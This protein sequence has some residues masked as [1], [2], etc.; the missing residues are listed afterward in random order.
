MLPDAP[1]VMKVP[2]LRNLYARVAASDDLAQKRSHQLR[3]F[4]FSHDGSSTSLLR[5]LRGRAFDFPKGDPQ[6]LDVVA[7]LMAFDSGLA[8]AVGQQV[9]LAPGPAQGL[10]LARVALLS[11]Q[12]SRSTDPACELIVKGT[13]NGEPRGWL[14]LASGGFRSDR[15]GEPIY[16]L[17]RLIDIAMGS[18]T[19]P[20]SPLTFTC[21]P[22]GAGVRMGL[23]RDEDGIFDRDEMDAGRNPA[24]PAG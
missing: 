19:V 8:P 18:A 21:V 12:A 1:Q 3:G 22:P 14:R 10:A 20:A 17:K 16:P 24:N 9:T 13:D 4:G 5:F 23:D 15:S 11:E 7:F 6:R 2:H